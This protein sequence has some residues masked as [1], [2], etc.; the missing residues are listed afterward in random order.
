[1][2][3]VKHPLISVIMPYYNGSKYI[4]EAIDSVVNQTYKNIEIIVINDGS[5]SQQDSI[6]IEDLAHQMQFS[7]IKHPVNKGIGQAMITGVNASKGDYLAELSQDDLYKPEKLEFQLNEIRNK[8]LDAVYSIGDMLDM[9]NVRL[10]ERNSARTKEIVNSGQAANRLKL[11]N[12][13][14]ISIQGLM[15]KRSVFE[16][17]IVDIWQNYLLDD[18]P[19]NIRLFEKYNINFTDKPLWTGRIHSAN[20]SRNIWKW[21]G[22]QIEVIARMT[23][24]HL[25]AEGTGNRI[26]SMARRLEK[27][28][29][30]PKIIAKLAFAALALTDSAQQ[31]KK[32]TRA[33]NKVNSKLKKNLILS[34][35]ANL[36]ALPEACSETG[37]TN[38]DV[39]LDWYDLGKAIAESTL[40]IDDAEKLNGIAAH[41]AALS[42]SLPADSSESFDCANKLAIAAY[43]LS[44]GNICD[45][46]ALDVLGSISSKNNNIITCKCRL[47]R[48]N[49]KFNIKTLLGKFT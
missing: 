36:E 31:H 37:A 39:N 43:L 22:P 11:Q 35:L 15:A 17:D 5:P 49:I 30:N 27:Q 16:N 33:L 10:I 8:N 25:R 46:Q 23:P 7:L 34:K 18:W 48:K 28:N 26:A 14:G 2:T 9:K 41:F 3:G 42:N 12:L 38:C 47:I 21:L 40:K 4:K 20:T 32:A 13:P 44:S 24:L 45:R 1:M 19:V 6:Y 29:A